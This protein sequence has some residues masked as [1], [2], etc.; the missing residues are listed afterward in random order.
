MRIMML[1]VSGTTTGIIGDYKG[2]KTRQ[3]LQL[4]HT[5]RV[6]NKSVR[7]VNIDIFTDHRY[8]Y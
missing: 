4:G 6:R 5:T 3:G 8:M 7:E 1:S 2:G